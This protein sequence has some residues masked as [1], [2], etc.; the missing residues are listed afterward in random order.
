M[1]PKYLA[2]LLPKAN[3]S[4]IANMKHIERPERALHVRIPAE[5]YRKVAVYCAENDQ[6][7]RQFVINALEQ[8]L[9]RIELAKLREEE[10]RN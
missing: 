7:I 4:I 1:V 5:L 9:S 8:D 2:I 6:T 10:E 3:N